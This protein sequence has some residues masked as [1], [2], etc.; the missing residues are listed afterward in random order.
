M[1]KDIIG[2]KFGDG[3]IVLGRDPNKKYHWLYQCGC[4]T[5]C[6]SEKFYIIGYGK[7]LIK[8]CSECARIKRCK[9]KRI[10]N[11]KELSKMDFGLLKIN[12]FFECDNK[13]LVEC[14]CGCGN[15]KIY[16]A[17]Y[18]KNKKK[19]S[20]G[21]QGPDEKI[22]K[23]N[24]FSR[25]ID[26]SGK[27][28]KFGRVVQKLQHSMYIIQCNCGRFFKKSQSQ[29]L[30]NEQ[31]SKIQGC[32]F[33]INE[34]IKKKAKQKHINDKCGMLT[35]LDIIDTNLPIQKSKCFCKCDCGKYITAAFINVKGGNTSS[36]GCLARPKKEKHPRWNPNLTEEDRI[37]KRIEWKTSNIS[38]EIFIRD[39]FTCQKCNKYGGT[40]NA[41]HMNSWNRYPEH[42]F[43]KYSIIT[44][45]KKCHNEFHKI[46]GWGN[47]YLEQSLEFIGFTPTFLLFD[48]I[49]L[50]L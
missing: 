50:G 30:N 19:K 32:K 15:K 42:R 24:K 17:S 12:R 39:N 16:P 37:Y 14:D 25:N 29:L 33:C 48:P 8:S 11:I 9:E 1:N 36:C 23:K 3:C 10:K 4:G 26:L 7:K 35:I 21:C 34:K 18:L 49:Y 38:S 13:L 5:I 40:L 2:L 28:M 27:F 45:C 43:N 41:H 20:C 44:L 31:L 47:N 46:Y 22:I 6:S